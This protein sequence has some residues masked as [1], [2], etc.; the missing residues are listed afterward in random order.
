MRW[1]RSQDR[2]RTVAEAITGYLFA[3]SMDALSE[4]IEREIRAAIERGDFDQLPGQ[5][6]PLRLD[7]DAFMAPELR[8]AYR[9]LRNSGCVPAEIGLLHEAAELEQFIAALGDEESARR[10][11]QRLELLRTQ[12]EAAGRPALASALAGPYRLKLLRALGGGSD[13]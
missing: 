13:T 2:G 6:Q 1:S 10:A 4:K 5:G 3:K 11:L 9:V 7:D 8:M 12:L